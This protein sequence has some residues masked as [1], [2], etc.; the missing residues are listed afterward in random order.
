M[1]FSSSASCLVVLSTWEPAIISPPLF[2]PFLSSSLPVRNGFAFMP[3]I[4]FTREAP[5]LTVNLFPCLTA[6]QKETENLSSW[7]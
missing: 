7:E 2:V 3:D 5:L 1:L 4:A 6:R